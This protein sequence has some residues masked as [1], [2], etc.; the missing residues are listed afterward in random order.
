VKHYGSNLA[1]CVLAMAKVGT[2]HAADPPISWTDEP[3]RVQELERL[4]DQA[5]GH[6][7][8]Q[9]VQVLPLP[10]VVNGEVGGELMAK[11]RFGDPGSFELNRATLLGVL[12]QSMSEEAMARLTE[13]TRH[14]DWVS[15]DVL[16]ESALSVVFDEARLEVLVTVPAEL[17]QVQVRD[18]SGLPD[19]ARGARGPANVSGFVTARGRG[20]WRWNSAE[21][22][23]ADIQVDVESALAVRGVV[24]EGGM[25]VDSRAPNFVRRAYTR[26]V[27]DDTKHAIR[28]TAGDFSSPFVALHDSIA[29]MGFGA[30]TNF[31]LRPYSLYR[32]VGR[33]EF[34]LET[35]SRVNIYINNVLVDTRDLDAGAHDIRNFPLCQ[36]ANNIRLVI[37]DG[38]GQEREL[39]FSTAVSADLLA[40]G[41]HQFSYGVGFPQMADTASYD[42]DNPTATLV[43]RLGVTDT[44]SLQAYGNVNLLDQVVGVGQAFATRYGNLAL[45]VGAGH[46]KDFDVLPAAKIRY[47]LVKVQGTSTVVRGVSLSVEYR[48]ETVGRFNK[49]NNAVS[50]ITSTASISQVLPR[51]SR[52]TLDAVHRFGGEIPWSDPATRVQLGV[53]SAFFKQISATAYAA[54]V[55][56]HG[57]T[58]EWRM[59]VT[60]LANF[61]QSHQRVRASVDATTTGELAQTV[62][63]A[64]ATPRIGSGTQSGVTLSQFDDTQSFFAHSEVATSRGTL[65]VAHGFS[66][67]G[68]QVDSNSQFTEI[69]AATS[70]AFADGLWGMS[71]PIDGSFVIVGRQERMKGQVL[72][73]NPSQDRSAARA[74]RLGA[75]V[76]PNLAAYLVAPLTLDA[77]NA[78]LGVEIGDNR[79]FLLPGYKTGTAVRVGT[80]A[81]ILIQGI[82]HNPDGSPASFL[83]GQVVNLSEPDTPPALLFTNGTGRFFVEG[84]VPG[85]YEIVSLTTEAN[86][87]PFTLSPDAEGLQAVG[88][89]TLVSPA[90]PQVMERGWTAPTPVLADP[91]E[92]EVPGLETTLPEVVAT[93]P[94]VVATLPEVVATLPEVVATLPEVVALRPVASEPFPSNDVKKPET[95][96]LPGLFRELNSEDAADDVSMAPVAAASGD[97]SPARKGSYLLQIGGRALCLAPP[98]ASLFVLIGL[99][100]LRRRSRS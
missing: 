61:R 54:H 50:G 20:T 67:D 22:K 92:V 37:L 96:V 66:S 41:V 71:S 38:T 47:D 7:S 14:L 72:Q 5:F 93:L 45:D 99:L 16:A 62:S 11:L 33:F 32:P 4:H 70:I 19:E 25:L 44:L 15:D 1:A 85:D 60:L 39:D 12:G 27:Y 82:L 28:Y 83:T 79:L 91:T 34:L 43:H 30:E 46:T 74:D 69:T 51:N 80:P 77:P 78:P 26:A 18:L 29:L 24:V 10:S 90:V 31:G 73:V 6:G 13:S 48:P 56:P 36:G 68:W 97:N 75:G 94:E 53:Q 88:T 63:W 9:Q 65:G 59:G 100:L 86:P 76:L 3:D 17:L 58:T 52:V 81:S 40:K 64:H 89:Y 57:S 87:L 55:K 21:R 2:A 98:V 35:R 84:L 23:A 8:G 95:I 42:W 49:V